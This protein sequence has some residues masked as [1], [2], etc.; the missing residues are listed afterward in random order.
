VVLGRSIPR[1]TWSVSLAPLLFLCGTDGILLSDGLT[2]EL[3]EGLALEGHPLLTDLGTQPHVEQGFLLRI[4]V[5]VV[6]TI[7]NKVYESL[8]VLDHSARTL[9]KV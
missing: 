1:R 8:L 9:L 6:R 5:N 4:H 7:L 3:V 2:H